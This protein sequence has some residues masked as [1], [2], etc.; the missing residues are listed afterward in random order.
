MRQYAIDVHVLRGDPGYGSRGRP[1]RWTVL[2][3][4]RD[5]CAVLSNSSE[6][7]QHRCIWLLHNLW[8]ELRLFQPQYHLRQLQRAA[9]LH[10]QRR[11]RVFG[12]HK[13]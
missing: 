1:V 9:R 10:L 2:V 5:D 6:R 7:V 12:I 8:K 4:G 11:L 13:L 3:R